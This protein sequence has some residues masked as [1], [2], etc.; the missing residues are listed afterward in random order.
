VAHLGSQA[1]WKKRENV[2]HLGSQAPW[3]SLADINDI[4]GT[5]PGVVPRVG[6]PFGPSSQRHFSERTEVA[7]SDT[8]RQ[9]C[10]FCMKVRNSAFMGGL[11]L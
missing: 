7:E 2:A 4:K 5:L 8:F 9:S 3:A 6:R 1:P 10:S 11:A